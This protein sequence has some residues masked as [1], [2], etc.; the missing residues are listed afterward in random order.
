MALLQYFRKVDT[1]KE[2]KPEKNEE[3]STNGPKSDRP[4]RHVSL[5]LL[6]TPIVEI[7]Y[8]RKLTFVELE[9]TR[10]NFVWSKISTFMV[11]SYESLFS[12]TFIELFMH[13]LDIVIQISYPYLL[14]EL[15]KMYRSTI[16]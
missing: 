9:E 7:L 13:T 6:T 10:Q 16:H 15:R 1:K 2:E 5:V 12:L 4:T 3:S 14:V 11:L 8:S